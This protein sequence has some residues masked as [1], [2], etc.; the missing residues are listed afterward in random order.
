MFSLFWVLPE[1]EC[2]LQE[3]GEFCLSCSLYPQHLKQYQVCFPYSI[4]CLMNILNVRILNRL[5]ILINGQNTMKE[6]AWKWRCHYRRGECLGAKNEAP[7]MFGICLL[8]WSR[9]V[10]W[11][12]LTLSALQLQG[13]WWGRWAASVFLHEV[14]YPFSSCLYFHKEGALIKEFGNTTKE[15]CWLN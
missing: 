6:K 8:S 4:K 1:L 9:A 5:G 10:I 14:L 15:T 12:K 3:G 11:F 2:K 7:R 13:Q